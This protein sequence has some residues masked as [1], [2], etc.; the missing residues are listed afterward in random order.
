MDITHDTIVGELVAEDYRT[1][2]IFKQNGIDFCCNGNR[3]IHAACEKKQ[4]DANALVAALQ[5]VTQKQ[6]SAAQ[7][8]KTWPLDL[9]ADY[10][11]KKHH[12]Y[13]EAK[14]QEIMPYLERIAQVHGD[15]HPELIEVAQLFH[16]S[17]GEFTVHM[18]KEELMLFPQI[19]KLAKAK[20]DNAVATPSPMGTV[21]NPIRVMLHDH[22]TEG[23]RWRRIAEL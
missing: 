16:E 7:D 1:A 12:S 23:E 5:E 21:Q 8:F 14:V 2:A 13:V 19:R 6:E 11:E 20:H 4:L 3:S 9:L 10:I 22:D 15:R 18:K 17:G